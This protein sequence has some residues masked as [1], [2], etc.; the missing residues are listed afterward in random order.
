VKKE[1]PRVRVPDSLCSKCGAVLDAATGVLDKYFKP[2]PGDVSVCFSCGALARFGPTLELVPFT[3]EDRLVIEE[4]EGL[5][6]LLFKIQEQVVARR[7][8]VGGLQ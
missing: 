6:K 4:Q 1:V 7:R 2:K 3:R 8:S 5:A